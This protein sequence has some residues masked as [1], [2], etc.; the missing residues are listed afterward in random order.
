MGQAR[1]RQSDRFVQGPDGA[2]DDRRRRAQRQAPSRPDGRR[3]HGRQHGLVARVRLRGEGLPAPHRQRHVLRGGEDPHDAGLRRERRAHRESGGHHADDHPA[4]DGPRQGDRRRDGRVPDGPVPQHR[5][6]RGLP[7]A[8][9]RAGRPARRPPR[10]GVHLRRDRG[11]LPGHDPGPPRAVP[12]G[13]PGGG[14]TGRIGGAERP[15]GRDAPHRG[16][17]SGFRAAA[18]GPR[19]GRRGHRGL[20]RRR[21][22]DGPPGD[23]GG[24]PLGRSLERGEPRRGAGRG[25]PARVGGARGHDPGRFG[26]EVPRRQPVRVNPL[27][28]VAGHPRFAALAGALCITFSGIF[29]RW[30]EVSPSTGVVFRCL[31]GLPLL[32]LAAW[33]ERRDLGPMSP[34]AVRLSAFAGRVLRGGPADVPLRR[35]QHRGGAGH[36]D[37]QPPGGDRRAGGVGPVGRAAAAERRHRAPDHAVRGRPDL[38]T[39]RRR[40]V[41]HE[42]AAR[43]RHRPRHRG[44]LRRLPPGHPAGHAGPSRRGSRDGRDGRLR[45][46]RG[47]LRH[48][49]RRLRPGA[50]A[51]V[52]RVPAG[53]RR[54]EPVDRLHPDPGV[55]AAAPGRAHLGDPADPAGDDRAVRGAA[56]RRGALTGADRRRRARRGRSGARDRCHRSGA[57]RPARDLR[58]GRL[59]QASGGRGRLRPVG[60][61]QSGLGDDV[62]APLVRVPGRGVGRALVVG[63]RP[64]LRVDVVRDAGVA[65]LDHAGRHHVRQAL[66]DVRRR[67]V[68]R[69]RP[70]GLEVDQREDDRPARLAVPGGPQHRAAGGAMRLDER[71]HGL[72]PHPDHPGRPEQGRRQVVHLGRREVDAV[73]HLTDRSGLRRCRLAVARLAPGQ[74]GRHGAVGI[75]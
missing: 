34:R 49:R 11:L 56:A 19:R 38:R 65:D 36:D 66:D 69:D 58:A 60:V 63:Q 30:S 55:A 17:R 47:G 45:A 37:G 1:E 6:D 43:R 28:A 70:Q 73:G 41:R 13:P 29:Y 31:Y 71:G 2:G 61:R 10:C 16:R 59:A 53:A 5:H 33:V 62:V 72:G 20:D 51:A 4:D 9:D 21:V 24:G 39:G 25:P 18:A 3:V 48:D 22:R 68:R 12:V 23:P 57:R 50:V 40:R 8:R 46:R 54:H 42:R 27:R 15:A 74:A 75:G 67:H 64:G 14:R 35:G 44:V 32:A 7:I 52:P 26:D